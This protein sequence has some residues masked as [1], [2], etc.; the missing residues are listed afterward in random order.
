MN[1]HFTLRPGK[2][3]V[4]CRDGSKEIV[5]SD[6]TYSLDMEAVCWVI[7]LVPDGAAPKPQTRSE[8]LKQPSC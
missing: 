3:K 4:A 6:G 1:Q 2:W 5:E 8:G 7:Y